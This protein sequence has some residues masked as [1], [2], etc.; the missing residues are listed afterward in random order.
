V[1]ETEGL[2]EVPVALV[3]CPIA[4]TPEYSFTVVTHTEPAERV[5]VTDEIEGQF[6]PSQI[7]T[8]SFVEL[9]VVFLNG[10][11]LHPVAITLEIEDVVVFQATPTTTLSPAVVAA[12]SEQLALLVEEEVCRQVV[13][14]ADTY[15]MVLARASGVASSN[16]NTNWNARLT[17]F[18][19]L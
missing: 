17:R 13:E 10:K 5:T 14:E 18:P 4:V 3:T 15:A 9:L 16:K 8:D 2:A 19:T 11:K 12:V 7:A 1:I 6:W